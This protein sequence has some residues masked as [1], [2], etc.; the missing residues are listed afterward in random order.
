MPALLCSG[1]A[2]ASDLGD[3][4][5]LLNANKDITNAINLTETAIKANA[6][7]TEEEKYYLGRSVGA[8]LLVKRKLMAQEDA[9]R[10]VSY[11]GQV[12]ALASDRPDTFK[13]YHF[14][15]LEDPNRVNAYAVPGGFIFVTTGL[16]NK[17]ENEDELAGV[18]AHEVAHIVLEH[19]TESIKQGYADELKKDL[20]SVA[21]DKI[22]EKQKDQLA[23]KLVTGLNVLSGQLIDNAAKGYSREKED[24]ADGLAVRIMVNAGYSPRAL[25]AVLRKLQAIGTGESGTHGNPKKRAT[26]VAEVIKKTPHADDLPVVKE[27]VARFKARLQTGRTP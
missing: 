27:R 9:Q 8:H 15:V 7:F 12:L 21:A 25:A 6:D 19:P 20:L 13:G 14:V 17:A 26:H 1:A 23:K 16:V 3:L 22:S 11:V 18:L 5:K 10:Y 4:A 24:D 2:G